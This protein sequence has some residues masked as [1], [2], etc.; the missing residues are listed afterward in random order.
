MDNKETK[1]SLLPSPE[2]WADWK[3]H[4]VTQLLREW[5][6]VRREEL[7]RTWETG[8]YTNQDPVA[9]AMMNAKAIAQCEVLEDFELLELDQFKE[10]DDA[11]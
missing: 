2:A 11:S 10:I 1:D 3:L 4:P 5:A 7:K 9:M 8:G 6:R